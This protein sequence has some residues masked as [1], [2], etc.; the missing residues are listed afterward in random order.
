MKML[1]LVPMWLVIHTRATAHAQLLA[2]PLIGA[3]RYGAVGLK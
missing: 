2:K 3:N 1:L